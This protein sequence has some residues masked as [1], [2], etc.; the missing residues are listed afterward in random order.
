MIEPLIQ[1]G[2]LMLH[3]IVAHFKHDHSALLAYAS[4]Y[5]NLKP[6]CAP[7]DFALLY[8]TRQGMFDLM[9]T[10]ELSDPV[11]GEATSPSFWRSLA[12]Y[13]TDSSEADSPTPEPNTAESLCKLGIGTDFQ[14]T[15]RNTV[16]P[17]GAVILMLT[18]N[19]NF[20]DMAHSIIRSMGG[21]VREFRLNHP[22]LQAGSARR[23]DS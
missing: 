9:E 8:R 11:L 6:S 20:F 13:L 21:S 1:T 10:V 14:H 7:L 3:L 16:E 17:G 22:D 4:L 15:F 5:R 12:D 18:E 19:G 2:C 23:Q